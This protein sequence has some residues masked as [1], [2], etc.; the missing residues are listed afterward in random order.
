VIKID[1]GTRRIGLSHNGVASSAYADADWDQV[2]AAIPD[3][4]DVNGDS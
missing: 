4:D 1:A 3:L 2:S